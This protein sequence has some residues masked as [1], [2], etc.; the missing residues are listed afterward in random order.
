MLLVTTLQ[1][2]NII[3]VL[4]CFHFI[5]VIVETNFLFWCLHKI[6][7][8]FHPTP[9]PLWTQSSINWVENLLVS[10]QLS[11]SSLPVSV[12]GHFTVFR[13]DAFQSL[14]LVTF[15]VRHFLNPFH[16][17]WTFFSDHRL[18]FHP[19]SQFQNYSCTFYLCVIGLPKFCKTLLMAQTLT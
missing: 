17:S 10:K 1:Y 13:V 12:C 15:W 2:K 8:I 6:R 11:C 18:H 9:L 16:P 19:H 7:N 14:T 3:F 5:K 4:S